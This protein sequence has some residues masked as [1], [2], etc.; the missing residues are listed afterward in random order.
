M[1]KDK[2]LAEQKANELMKA[3][4]NYV[5]ANLFSF[6]EESHNNN[7]IRVSN[8]VCDEVLKEV[9]RLDEKFNLG[10]EGTKEFWNEVKQSLKSKMK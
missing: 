4:Y 3:A 7:C 8:I 6:R 5:H 10:L 2:S 1:E 9:N